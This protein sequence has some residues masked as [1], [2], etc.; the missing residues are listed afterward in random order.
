M[1]EEK[2]LKR[3]E[4]YKGKILHVVR[5]EILLPN[6]KSAFREVNYHNGGACI[7]PYTKSGNIILVQQYRYAIGMTTLE[8]PAGKIDAGESGLSCAKRELSEEVGKISDNIT[9]LGIFYG[10][11]AILSEKIYMYLATDLIDT[12]QKL[13][14]D[15]FLNIIELPFDKALDMIYSNQIIDGKTIA[16]I[17]KAKFILNI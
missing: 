15:E 16:A 1:F 13:D 10:S 7:L 9:D 8:I 2:F 6:G 4:K 12:P 5:D 14:D 3:E 17:F 11:P